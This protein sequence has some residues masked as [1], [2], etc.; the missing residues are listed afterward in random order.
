MGGNKSSSMI[1]SLLGI[2]AGGFDADAQ[3]F[4]DA[5]GITDET[6]QNAINQLVID[7]HGYS[8]WA[9]MIAVYPFV[10]G[11][12]FTHKWNLVDPRDLDAA[13]RLTYQG[14]DAITHSSTGAKPTGRSYTKMHFIPNTNWS[15]D[16][17]AHISYYARDLTN[18]GVS[19]LEIGDPSDSKTYLAIK[20]F[21]VGNHTITNINNTGL[22]DVWSSPTTGH[23]LT[24]RTGSSSYK[25]IYPNQSETTIS[26]SSTTRSSQDLYLFGRPSGEKCTKECAFA[27]IGYGLTKTEANNLQTAVQTFNTSL[28]RQV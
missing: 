27:S 24:T 13:H 16:N 4:I 18:S 14:S 23:S 10:G 6:Q 21:G 9:S 5:A 7:L 8:L 1:K 2:K 12:A 17:D 22:H 11:T 26:T 28:S 15:S 25:F 19:D 20:Y 3:A